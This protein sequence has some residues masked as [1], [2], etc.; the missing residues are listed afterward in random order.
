M[1]HDSTKNVI[2]QSFPFQVPS[3]KMKTIIK[4]W[5]INELGVI[6]MN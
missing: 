1:K 6:N 3:K 2:F 5:A 4:V